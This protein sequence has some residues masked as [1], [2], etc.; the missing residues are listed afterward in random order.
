MI[1][2]RSVKAKKAKSVF[3]RR[4]NDI[5]IFVEDTEKGSAKLYTILFQRAF[6]GRYKI[7]RIH[8]LGGKTEVLKCWEDRNLKSSRTELYVI[9]SD[10][11]LTSFEKTRSPYN[12]QGKGLFYTSRFCIEN[13]LIN[14]NAALS[15][16]DKKDPLKQR[17]ELRKDLNF[18]KWLGEISIH[19]KK[20]FFHLYTARTI[21]EDIPVMKFKYSDVVKNCEGDID[22]AKVDRICAET[23]EL[24]L[25]YVEKEQWDIIFLKIKSEL[26][27]KYSNNIQFYICGKNFLLGLLILKMKSITDHREKNILIKQ[28]LARNT[29]S[30]ILREELGVANLTNALTQTGRTFAA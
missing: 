24:A 28:S 19:L 7:N 30:R 9:D 11:S 29:S 12:C 26:L 8:P 22:E 27:T 3:F 23:K 13:Y 5:D 21:S 17:G 4:I 2:K 1:P 14:E 18:R 16:L 20:L 6:D 10:F 15:Y 25:K